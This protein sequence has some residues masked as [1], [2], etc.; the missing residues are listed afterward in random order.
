MKTLLLL[1]HAKSSRDDSTL[2]DFDRP[3]NDRGKDDAKLMGRW[4]GRQ[5]IVLDAVISSPAKRARQTMEIFLK[6][7][8]VS[9]AASFDERIYEA[10]LQQLLTIVSEIDSSRN[11]VLLIG[12]NPGFEDLAESLTGQHSRLATAALAGIEL[13]VEEW[14][15]VRLRVGKLRLLV[16]PKELRN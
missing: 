14:R 11:T 7:A 3:L 16:T 1:R 5:Q 13:T 4:L 8:D 12:H 6:A 15:D 2:N 9:L 10:G